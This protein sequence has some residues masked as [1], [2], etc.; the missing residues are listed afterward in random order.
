MHLYKIPFHKNFQI[1][2]KTRLKANI[3]KNYFSFICITPTEQKSDK[4]IIGDHTEIKSGIRSVAPSA[5]EKI[6]K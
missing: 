2:N 6:L 4:M 5:V 1:E 3:Y